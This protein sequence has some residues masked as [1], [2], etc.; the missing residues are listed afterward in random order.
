[1]IQTTDHSKC[2]LTIPALK[3]KLVHERSLKIAEKIGVK[4]I[5]LYRAGMKTKFGPSA[6]DIPCVCA[7][8][9]EWEVDTIEW[10]YTH[11]QA[12]NYYGEVPAHRTTDHEA[13]HSP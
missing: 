2:L 11:L 8:P 5:G 1:M 7:A 4:G 10:L 3:E 9:V 13:H 6:D 12:R